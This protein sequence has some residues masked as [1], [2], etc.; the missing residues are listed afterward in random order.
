MEFN[1]G[2]LVRVK[3]KDHSFFR[4]GTR[5]G[6]IVDFD[7]PSI[8]VEFPEQ[9]LKENGVILHDGQLGD[10][11]EIRWWFVRDDITLVH[12]SDVSPVI[13]KIRAMDKRRKDMGYAW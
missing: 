8:L 12:T 7:L 1:I 6:I 9:E 11:K 13:R 5:E 2:D 4:C 3:D 10:D